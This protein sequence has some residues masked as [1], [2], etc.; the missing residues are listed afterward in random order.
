MYFSL[1]SL[2][3]SAIQMSKIMPK[4]RNFS[5]RLKFIKCNWKK[6]QK[7]MQIFVSNRNRKSSKTQAVTLGIWLKSCM[8]RLAPYIIEIKNPF[9]LSNFSFKICISMTVC[10][11]QTWVDNLSGTRFGEIGDHVIDSESTNFINIAMSNWQ[12][13]GQH[14]LSCWKSRLA[15]WNVSQPKLAVL[16]EDLIFFSLNRRF[17][18]AESKS[19]FDRKGRTLGPIFLV[20]SVVVV[21]EPSGWSSGWLSVS[22][23]SS[24]PS[25]YSS[26]WNGFWG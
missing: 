26:S 15:T 20:A 2:W 22:W 4:K 14:L 16:P 25:T 11:I 23:T 1:D 13:L 10:S 8:I 19:W 12:G 9:S 7:V 5:L 18:N 6:F 17:F 3:I 21:V 24:P